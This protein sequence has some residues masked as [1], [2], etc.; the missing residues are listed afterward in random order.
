MRDSI[1]GGVL[2]SYL[3]LHTTLWIGA[4]G[5]ATSL[6]PI[7]LSPVPRLRSLPD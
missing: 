3:G 2:G 5:F 1:A 6:L 7:L 4:V